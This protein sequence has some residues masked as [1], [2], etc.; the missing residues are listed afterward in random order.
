[1]FFI[2]SPGRL[3][4][5]IVQLCSGIYVEKNLKILEVQECIKIIIPMDTESVFDRILHDKKFL[6]NLGKF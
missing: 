3:Q 5:M 6:A 4:E 2:S 1:M